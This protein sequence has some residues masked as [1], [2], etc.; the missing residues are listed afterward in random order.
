MIVKPDLDRKVRI[1]AEAAR[2]DMSCSSRGTALQHAGAGLGVPMQ[3]GV[4]HS[5]SANGHC[6]PLLKVLFSNA[7]VYNCAYC[8]NR[9]DNDAPRTTFTVR[10]L[11]DLTINFYRHDY[12]KGLFLSSAVCRSPDWT[13]ERLVRVAEELRHIH[14]F[15]GYIHLKIIPGADAAFLTR[16]GLVADRLSV[17]IEL[18]SE[19][20]L[21][22]LAPDKTREAVLSP[23]LTLSELIRQNREDDRRL[24]ATPRFVPA[25]QSTQ[26]II[27]ASPETDQRILTLAGALYNNFGLKRVYYSGYVPVSRDSRL[28]ALNSP[29][30]LREHRLYQAD[31]LLRH[32]GFDVAE[33][34]NRGQSM[35]D[36]D[37]DPKS[38]W[39]LRHPELF[40][41]EANRACLEQLIRIPGVGLRSAGKIIAARRL[42]PLHPENLRKLG[43]LMKR[44]RYFL[45]VNGKFPPGGGWDPTRA[46]A[47]LRNQ[48]SGVRPSKPVQLRFL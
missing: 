9:S 47:D 14:R 36:Q 32:Y 20:S 19:Q 37:L 26:M 6:I 8:V 1:L 5:L 25:G 41:M 42:G 4:F 28:P 12:I 35:L 29:P 34:F 48:G 44:A 7:C 31:W 16:A 17:N 24:S 23:M 11:V 38:A 22:I 13:M 3:T 43:V 18:P 39:A 21:K 27:G 15:S 10:E 46:G 2:Y 33:I 30:L 40:P 45:T